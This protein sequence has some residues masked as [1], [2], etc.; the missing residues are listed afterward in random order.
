MTG[1]ARC[2]WYSVGRKPTSGP[3]RESGY[4]SLICAARRSVSAARGTKV[5]Y[6]VVGEFMQPLLTTSMIRSIDRGERMRTATGR[7]NGELRSLGKLIGI[8]GFGY[9]G[10]LGA[11]GG[12]PSR[13]S[14]EACTSA[15]GR[16]P[17]CGNPQP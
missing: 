9:P 1:S 15:T 10:F 17:S 2:C 4:G 5:G 12:E 13:V 16:K 14:T 11:N 8:V 6:R 3:M 7:I